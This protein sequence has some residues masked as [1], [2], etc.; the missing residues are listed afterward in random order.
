MYNMT[1]RHKDTINDYNN[2]IAEFQKLYEATSTTN[3]FVQVRIISEIRK[4]KIQE[5]EAVVSQ[6]GNGAHV[7]VPKEWLG[8]NVKV[9]LLE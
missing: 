4:P 7:F 3:H 5:I 1:W 9:T 8:K 6:S 2:L